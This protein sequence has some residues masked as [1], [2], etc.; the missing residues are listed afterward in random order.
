MNQFFGL[1]DERLGDGRMRMA[2]TAYRDAAAEIQ[3]AFAGDVINIT[4]GAMAQ[5]EFKAAVARHYVLREQF[6]DG[7]VV[8][9]HNRRRRWNYLLHAVYLTAKARKEHK[10]NAF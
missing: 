1:F 6:A 4:S 7:L 5:R 10:E 2:Q 9:P 8:I 3:I